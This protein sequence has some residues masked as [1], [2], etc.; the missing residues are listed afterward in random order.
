MAR[1]RNTVRATLDPA[2]PK[3]GKTDWARVDA[4]SE[5][6]INAAAKSDPDA[7]LWTTEEL[8]RARR[9]V[10]VK[11]IRARSRLSQRQF[12]ET[13]G[14]SIRTVQDWE[15]G[16]Y[17]PDGPARVLLTVIDRNPEAV[18]KALGEAN[19]AATTG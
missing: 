14:L 4:M 15:Q 8:K 16:R 19:K 6:E 2:R 12:A 18:K 9:V 1:E 11:A 13:F 5:E 3:R 7:Q 17:T 10:D